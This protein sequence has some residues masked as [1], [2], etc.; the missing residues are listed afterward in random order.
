M[1]QIGSK[2]LF[3]NYKN[4]V[5]A[6][7][8]LFQKIIIIIVGNYSN[9]I[10]QFHKFLYQVLAQCARQRREKRDAVFNKKNSASAEKWTKLLA[11]AG[12]NSH[13]RAIFTYN[14]KY[15]PLASGPKGY[16]RMAAPN[17]GF[18]TIQLQSAIFTKKRAA[19]SCWAY[20]IFQSDTEKN[21]QI[22]SL[23]FQNSSYFCRKWQPVWSKQN[24]P[25]Q[26]DSKIIEDLTKLHK[27][28]H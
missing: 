16:Y 1:K 27:K 17:N 24:W 12:R 13:E 28:Y 20:L 22:R 8:N 9:S 19:V 5:F 23:F 2:I 15:P 26:L 4:R 3:K 25:T 11:L 18:F 14:Q 10:T 6:F 7:W 21:H